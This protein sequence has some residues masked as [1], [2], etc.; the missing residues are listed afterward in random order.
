MQKILKKVQGFIDEYGLLAPGDSVLAA[1]SGGADSVCLLFVLKNLCPRNGWRLRAFHL[2]HGLRGAEAD[3]DEA[4]VRE[5]CGRLQVPL[6]V[7]HRDV[8]AYAAAERISTE[9]AGRILR[10]GALEEEAEAWGGGVG[11]VKI[12]VAHHLDDQAET[13]LHHLLRGSGLRGLSGMRPV[14]GR[15]VRPLLCVRREEILGYLAALG[16]DWC[17]DSTNASQDYTRNRIRGELL[18]LMA[19]AVNQRAAEHICGAGELFF[20]ADEYLLEQA[21]KV[22]EA[23]RGEGGT[24]S[25]VELGI[26]L[27]QKPVIRS[28]MIRLMLEEQAPGQKNLTAR[29]FRQIEELAK[30]PVGGCCDLP[31]RLAAG[32]GYDTLWVRR[33]DRGGHAGQASWPLGSGPAAWD[34]RTGAGYAGG[35]YFHT[36]SWQKGGEIQKNQYTKWFDYDKIKGT[37]SVRTRQ[38]GDFLMLAGGGRKMVNRYMI[39]ERIPKE[40][41]DRI[42]LLAEG[43]HVLWVIGYRISDYYKITAQT[44]NVLQVERTEEERNGR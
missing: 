1:V 29:H 39:D 43:S 20:Q 12:A 35:L 24:S 36:F 27:A 14:Q 19:R 40:E 6:T 44:K 10:Y 5:L 15:K 4:F 18:P 30:G 7:V 22:M 13:I 41:R 3:R 37:L 2:H 25:E 9:E 16:Q 31:G 8:A 34:P 23:G 21:R 26:F 42:P 38:G 11:D 33:K 17:E 32:R 28:Y